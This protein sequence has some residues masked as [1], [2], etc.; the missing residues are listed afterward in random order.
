MLRIIGFNKLIIRNCFLENQM[1]VIAGQYR[2]RILKSP[3]DSK[4]RPTSDRLRE[5]LFNILS[6]RIDDE[7]RVLDLCA[8]TGAVGIE[9]LSRGANYATFV[10]KS[11]KMCGLIEQNLDNL[12]IPEEQTEVFHISAEDFLRRSEEKV[13]DI[14]YFDPPYESDYLDVL[15]YFADEHKSYLSAGGVLIVEHSSKV[16]MPDLIG[17]LRR[18][19]LLKQ[20]DSSLSFFEKS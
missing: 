6:P 8:G 1:R 4:T 16:L 17:D 12:K 14:I 18:W 10:D 3:S 13:W 7:T 15:Q 2:G 11:R 20:G 19:R 9:A 5:T